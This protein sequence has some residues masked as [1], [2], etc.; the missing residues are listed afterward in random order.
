MAVKRLTLKRNEPLDGLQ[1]D[2]NAQ[3]KQEDTIEKRAQQLDSLPAERQCLGRIR[4][5]GD[6]V[7]MST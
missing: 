3:T 1:E 4:S 2:A 5:L 6:L 7:G